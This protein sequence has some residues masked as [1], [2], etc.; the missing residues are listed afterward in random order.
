M[1][2][3]TR[4]DFDGLI[5]GVLLSEVENVREFELV[6]AKD[7][8]DNL[9]PINSN[10]IIANLPYHPQS[11]MWF[12]HHSSELAS[13][14]ANVF[15]GSFNLAPSCASVIYEH[16]SQFDALK[17]YEPIV[18]EADKIDAARFNIDDIKNPRD[19]VLL[20]KTMHIYDREKRFEDTKDYFIRL[21]NY[22]CQFP[23]T[24]VLEDREVKKRIEFL[25]EE[26]Q[27]YLDAIT[28]YSHSNGNVIITDFRD[29]EYIPNGDKFLVY[30]LFPKQNVS[31]KVFN[32]R[33]TDDTV[34]S[35][36]YSIFNRTCDKHIGELM[37]KYGGGGHRAAGSCRVKQ[38]EADQILS[39]LIDGLR[40]KANIIN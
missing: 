21:L 29:V 4:A 17:K 20:S 14:E 7:I 13:A 2:L 11:G 16:Y 18:V 32:K 39:N 31:L 26:H 25:V 3:V 19:W 28:Q 1:R 40:D 36:G 22:I 6:H 23:L 8:H 34:I 27:T 10:D 5:C 30:T 35:C 9:V 24:L 15:N 38:K 37:Q 33:K 12:D